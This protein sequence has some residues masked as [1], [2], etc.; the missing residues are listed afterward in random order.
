MSSINNNVCGFVRRPRRWLGLLLAGAVTGLAAA[1]WGAPQVIVLSNAAPYTTSAFLTNGLVGV[2]PTNWVV[3]AGNTLDVDPNAGES[4]SMESR[5]TLSTIIFSHWSGTLTADMTADDVLNPIVKDLVI[6]GPGTLTANYTNKAS[7]R[8]NSANVAQG[9]TTPVSSGLSTNVPV[10]RPIALTAVPATG[11]EFWYWTNNSGNVSI[12]ATNSATTF[13]T[14]NAVAG[15]PTVTAYF[16]LKK[17]LQVNQSGSGS[18]YINGLLAVSGVKNYFESG[19]TVDLLAV[20][21]VAPNVF[22]KWTLILGN[23]V[24]DPTASSTSVTVSNDTVLSLS[25]GLPGR[26]LIVQAGPNGVTTPSGTNEYADGSYVDITATA[27]NGYGFYKWTTINGG[28]INPLLERQNP[29]VD[30]QMNQDRNYLAHF[31]N[32]FTVTVTDAMG[33]GSGI[34]DFQVLAGTGWTNSP[35]QTRIPWAGGRIEVES[36]TNGTGDV[37]SGFGNSVTVNKATTDSSFKWV[38]QQYYSLDTQV[39]GVGQVFPFD[40][41]LMWRKSG[42]VQT[43]T[44]APGTGYTLYKWIVN[45]QDQGHQDLSFSLTMNEAKSVTAIFIEVT[46][47]SDKDHMPDWWEVKYGLNPFSETGED[48]DDGDPDRDGVPNWEEFTHC[49]T[50]SPDGYLA[51]LSP[52]NADSDGDGMDDRFELDKMDPSNAPLGY[53]W[54]AVDTR[55]ILEKGPDGNPDEDFWW[56]TANGYQEPTRPL[57]NIDEWRGPDSIDPCTYATVAGS[58]AFASTNVT[59]LPVKWRVPAWPAING[60]DDQSNPQR[61]DTDGDKFDDG[62]EFSWD[63]W[64]VAHQGE[65]ILKNPAIWPTVNQTVPSWV[66]ARRYNPKVRRDASNSDSTP[67]FDLLYD[68]STGRPTDPWSDPL[69]YQASTLLVS[70]FPGSN[71]VAVV[72]DPV[73]AEPWCTNPF[74]W[75]TDG[76]GLSDGW[77]ISFGYD[78]WEIDSDSNSDSDGAENPDGEGFAFAGTVPYSLNGTNYLAPIC[79]ELVLAQNDFNPW[80]GWALHDTLAVDTAPYSNI[81]EMV[82]ADLSD[83]TNKPMGWIPGASAYST[84]PRNIDTDNDGMWDGW[85][86]YESQNPIDPARFLLSPNTDTDGALDREDDDLL[87]WQEFM[88]VG[89]L[90]EWK[91]LIQDG[92]TPDTINPSWTAFIDGWA[93]K[94]LPSDPTLI[95]RMKTQIIGDSDGDQMSDLNEM[96]AFN[97]IGTAWTNSLVGIPTTGIPM[98]PGGGLDP[99]T[100]DTDVDY[101][102]DYW[103]AYF[104]GTFNSSGSVAVVT[105]IT[106][107]NITGAVVTNVNPLANGVNGTVPDATQ[108]PD[109]D[110]VYNY[111]EYLV[112]A[113]YQF[114]Y[115]YNDGT[116]TYNDPDAVANNYDPYNFFDVS[117]SGNDF[118]VGPGALAPYP[119]DPAFWARPPPNGKPF[120][121]LS[122][123]I[124]PFLAAGVFQYSTCDPRTADTDHDGYD[125]FYELYHC[126]NPIRG[127]MDRVAGKLIAEPE[128]IDSFYA[129]PLAYDA[130]GM[131]FRWGERPDGPVADYDQDGEVDVEENL[132]LNLPTALAYYHTDPSPYSIADY[133]SPDSYVNRFYKTGNKFGGLDRFWFWDDDVLLRNFAPAAYLFSFEANEGYDT[134]NDLV[135]DGVEIKGGSVADPNLGPTDPLDDDS[136]LKQRALYLN[137]VD[138][139]A[140]MYTPTIH[141]WYSF[142]SFTAEAWVRPDSVNGDHVVVERA[143]MVTS[144]NPGLPQIP[145]VTRNF[146][147][148]IKD[149]VPYA[150][151][152]GFGTNSTLQPTT[153]SPQ[154]SIAAN[155]WVHLAVVFSETQKRLMLYVNGE[156]A[157][158]TPVQAI[159]F[160]GYVAQDPTSPDVILAEWMT[161]TVGASDHNPNAICDGTLN[162]ILSGQYS[163]AWGGNGIDDTPPDLH[164]YFHGYVD[165]VHLWDG[166]LTAAQVKYMKG[167]KLTRALLSMING[168]TTGNQSFAGDMGGSEGNPKILYAFTFDGLPDPYQDGNGIIPEGF[169]STVDPGNWSQVEWWA[170]FS[171]NSTVYTDRRYVKWIQNMATHQPFDPPR[172]T[173]SVRWIQ[174]GQ[175]N[176]FPN[177]S[178][179]YTVEYIHGQ[180]GAWEVHPQYSVTAPITFLNTISTN[181]AFVREFSGLYGDLLPLGGARGA[182][183]ITMWDGSLPNNLLRDQ[184][185][186]GMPDEWERANGLDWLDPVDADDDPDRD[187]L[188]NRQEY[189]SGSKPVGAYSVTQS[190]MDF[191]SYTN[192]LVGPYRFLGEEYT[193]MDY[194]DDLWEA[195]YGLNT[196]MFDSAGPNADSDNDGWSNLAEF[197]ELANYVGTSG[198]D[199]SSATNLYAMYAPLANDT[200]Y[201]SL[202]AER[203]VV[204]GIAT[205]N[206]PM[207]ERLHPVPELKFKFSYT[208]ISREITDPHFIVL[209]YSDRKME[210]PVASIRGVADRYIGYPRYMSLNMDRTNIANLIFTDPIDYFMIWQLEYYQIIGPGNSMVFDGNVREGLNW[211]WGF[212]DIN[213][214]NEYQINEPAGFAGPVN[215][216]WGSV[217]PIE[218]PLTDRRPMGF[219]RFGWPRDPKA[220]GYRVTIVDRNVANAPTVFDRTFSDNRTFVHEGDLLAYN[221]LGKGFKRSGGYQFYVRSIYDNVE[222]VITNGMAYAKYA[223]PMPAPELIWPVGNVRLRQSRDTFVWKMD[224]SATK[225]LM[226]VKRRDTGATVLTHSFIPP[227]LDAQG[228]SKMEMP[229]YI[230]DGVFQNGTYDYT[231]TVQTPLGSASSTGQFSVKVGDYAGYSYSLSG[232]FIYPGKVPNGVFVAEAFTSPGFGGVAVGRRLIAN[233][234]TSAAWPTNVMPF[235]IRGVP[236]GTY[237]VRVFLDQNDV[238]PNYTADDFESQ[239]WLSTQFHWPDS[240]D[241]NRTATTMFT[242]WIKVLL[243]DTDNDRLADDWEYRW[244]ANLT[245]FG[246][247]DMGGYTPALNGVLNVF[248]CYGAAPLGVSPF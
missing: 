187:G 168:V 35:P 150:S 91:R 17:Y 165:E 159:P 132:T 97:Y 12:S 175:T 134:D 21:S 3:N 141:S 225:C 198:G 149:G 115:A 243:R 18:F 125:D 160:N 184:D 67:D 114:Q 85:E 185:G 154:F 70:L 98:I 47:S 194:I 59:R 65:S 108:D 96:S 138:S 174:N 19:D 222:H 188:S 183:D 51:F 109:L 2:T 89:V 4:I 181:T 58:T 129:D 6:Y 247:G 119:W 145:Q 78:P 107:N 212:M 239:G 178:N 41:N 87:N 25:F 139:A 95:D 74:M 42:T 54:A 158:S 16:R 232:S 208:G 180:G 100:A 84:N 246:I 55:G 120:T 32:L 163:L 161:V 213:G 214:D 101:L 111:Q 171:L 204:P 34:S 235:T 123:T 197:Q 202:L 224:T 106:T 117:L 33:T 148:G 50:N 156:L 238:Y 136:P 219:A 242:D 205:W 130:G 103:E 38:W 216:R 92:R 7:L 244:N 86:L 217:G 133:S 15:T 36:W 37:S 189:L 128:A 83:L 105:I 11:F 234:I 31:T 227:A 195:A 26:I 248:Q 75:D 64:Q 240:V 30:V 23:G 9:N 113:C 142:R 124:G 179:P 72:R 146:R 126:L 210:M 118:Q 157:S 110:G 177:T 236:A 122:A 215:V 28:G 192:G 20:N 211:F 220:E 152:D 60:T 176:N 116:P 226:T 137:G 29:L 169:D 203:G 229:I 140:R 14:V 10:G 151:Y 221:K 127:D 231:L 135:A 206:N 46:D 164:D 131:W 143:G 81:Y 102:P 166:A 218:I 52:I 43:I 104:A 147:L 209:A 77:E 90:A 88:S 201:Q 121:F 228:R 199:F 48:G 56:N 73:R 196:E 79:H 170:N 186:D 63:Q 44:A 69:E 61:V 207:D 173:R 27:S 223:S 155:E 193:D 71:N 191:F 1:S 112:G 162:N 13:V 76:D 237:Y 233:T 49:L 153:T 94:R 241:V 190:V 245:S 172:D 230:G 5:P 93:N 39:S 8:V 68:P 22:K 99:C 66:T 80:T 24:N 200:L 45:G 82:G 167:I 53:I 57:S 144:G 62:Y 182:E 40:T